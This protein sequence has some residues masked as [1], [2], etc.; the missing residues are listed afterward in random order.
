ML[1]QEM[2]ILMNVDSVIILLRFTNVDTTE[3]FV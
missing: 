2:F 3:R 1:M